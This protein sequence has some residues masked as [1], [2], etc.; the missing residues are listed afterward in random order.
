[1]EHGALLFRGF[2]VTTPPA[3]EQFAQ[4]LCA[5]LYDENGEHPHVSVSGK[6]YTPVFYPP[7]LKLLWHNENSF[8]RRWP[9]RIWFCCAKPAAQ[10]GETPVADSRKVFELLDPAIRERFLEKQIM[11]VRNYG[12]GLGLN[13]Q[14]V[15][16]TTNKAEVEASCRDS[17]MTCE[18]KDGDRLRTRCVRPAA[19]KHPK[20]GEMVWFNQ[21]QHWHV[22]CL[23]P[24][25]GQ[26]LKNLFGEADLPRSCY[27]GDGSPIED[28]TMQAILDVYQKLEVSFPWEAGDVLMLD[29]MLTAHARN[30]FGG[31]RKIL[32]TMGEMTGY[33]EL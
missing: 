16:G 25:T 14:D 33:E 30:P 5:E 9:M 4:T 23:D 6:V 31:E 18:W 28:S 11:Y 17:G 12:D 32:V 19:G 29:N 13:W 22:S 20:T 24:D 3:F 8:N 26:A 21:A 27:Y 15:F 7:T 1:M 10:G 2:N